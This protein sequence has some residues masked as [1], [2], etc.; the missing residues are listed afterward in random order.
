M[1]KRK[2]D[3]VTGLTG[4]VAACSRKTRSPVTRAR[5]Q[6]GGP[7]RVV[8]EGPDAE[9]EAKHIL[10]ATGSKRRASLPG[11]ELDGDRDRDQHRG[12]VLSAEVPGHLVV[13][14]A[15]LHR[16]GDGHRCGAARG[17]GHRARVPRPHP[18][19]HGHGDRREAHKLLRSQGMSFHLKARVT[20]RAPRPRR[21][22]DGDGAVVESTARSR[23]LRSRAGGGG[24]HAEHR[25]SG[26][27][28]VGLE[29]DKRGRIPVDEHF[30]T[31]AAACTPSAT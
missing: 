8:V 18:A 6:L 4:G 11:V 19:G 16:P 22:S 28:S 2:D 10:I 30:R 15:R 1:L 21:G 27:G 23:S 24:A 9:L 29:L 17:E 14:G 5:A 13:I 31:A 12:A 26:P 7:G 25:R 3:V 20:R